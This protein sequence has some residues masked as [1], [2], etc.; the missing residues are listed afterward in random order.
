M[1]QSKRF[2]SLRAGRS[3]AGVVLMVAAVTALGTLVLGH[4]TSTDLVMLYLLAVVISGLRWGMGPAVFSAVLGGL[5]FD[6]FMLPPRLSFTIANFDLAIT[7]LALIGVALVVGMLTGRLRDHASTLRQREQETASLYAFSREMVAVQDMT[8]I[9]GAIIKHLEQIL[10][11]PVALLVRE[12]ERRDPLPMLFGA[13]LPAEEQKAA[14]WSLINARPCGWDEPVMADLPLDCIPLKSA[15]AV[16][17][18]LV[19]RHP[20]GDNPLTDG[21]RRLLEAFA[22]QAAV[23]LERANLAETARKAEL[24][25]ETE[26]LYDALLH[27]VSH[28]LRTPLASIIGGLST[29]LDPGQEELDAPTRHELLEMAREEAERL[30]G[31]VGNLLDMTRLEAGRLKLNIDWYDMADVI[32]AALGQTA[33]RLANRPVAVQMPDELPLVP[34]DQVLVVHV[35]ENLLDNADKYSPPGCPIAIEVVREAERLTVTVADRGAGIAADEAERIFEKFY[36]VERPGSPNG[37][38]LG[39]A[40]CR[41]IVE[42][43][44]GQ[45]WAQ[46][47]QGGGTAVTFALPLQMKAAEGGG[48]A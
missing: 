26:K 48:T 13:A 43:H 33:D 9:A 11:R 41:G 1:S 45:I 3:Y 28:A 12:A 2:A 40:I 10:G 38:G 17:G 47:R 19:V 37:I 29:V 35:L 25:L 39:L 15:Q 46:P 16:V 34:L 20:A 22:A 31:L 42:A 23:V 6:F 44:R 18:V 36:R 21:E 27:S 14:R 8:A 24:L 5:T 30:N 32:G 4:G 7:F